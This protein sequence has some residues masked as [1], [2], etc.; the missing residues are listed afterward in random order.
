MIHLSCSLTAD[1]L[2]SHYDWF[3]NSHLHSPKCLEH[4]RSL[5]LVVVSAWIVEV[6]R[7][8]LFTKDQHTFNTVMAAHTKTL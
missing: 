3:G 8:L 2:E 5:C 4:Y 6:Y 7:H 1:H